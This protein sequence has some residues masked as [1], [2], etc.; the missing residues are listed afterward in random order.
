[1]DI[2]G[3]GVV[4]PAQNALVNH[5]P[6]RIVAVGGGGRGEVR[7]EA[8]LANEGV[9]EASPFGVVGLGEVEL[10]GTSVSVKEARSTEEAEDS[11]SERSALTWR[12]SGGWARGQRRARRRLLEEQHRG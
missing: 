8:K 11:P 1:V 4:Q 7:A 3:H 5:D 9:E 6:V 10:D 12:G 2:L